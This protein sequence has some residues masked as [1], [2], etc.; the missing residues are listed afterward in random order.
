M[1]KIIIMQCTAI[2][3]NQLSIDSIVQAYNNP[4]NLL[5]ESSTGSEYVIINESEPDSSRTPNID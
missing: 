2:Y 5:T 3:A 1:S 4:N